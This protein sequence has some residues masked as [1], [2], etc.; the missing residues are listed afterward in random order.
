M[1]DQRIQYSEEMVGADHPTKSDTLGRLA[2]V[3]C[4]D[5]GKGVCRYL[6]KQISDP[7]TGIDEGVLFAKES[8]GALAVF[9]QGPNNAAPQRLT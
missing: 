7:E 8:S 1:S 2:L 5:D 6:V 3:E 4:G 9:W